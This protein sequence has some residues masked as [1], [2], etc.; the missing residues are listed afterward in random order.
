M[1]NDITIVNWI[2]IAPPLS[3]TGVKYVCG[4]QMLNFKIWSCTDT[5]KIKQIL[6][7]AKKKRRWNNLTGRKVFDES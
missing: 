5:A 4:R 6:E 7:F 1:Q 2:Y 3:C